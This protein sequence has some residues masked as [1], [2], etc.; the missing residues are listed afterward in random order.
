M[1]ISAKFGTIW[2]P[3]VE[4]REEQSLVAEVWWRNRSR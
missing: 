2:Q 3:W 4:L 1:A